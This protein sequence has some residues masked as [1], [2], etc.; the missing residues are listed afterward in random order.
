MIPATSGWGDHTHMLA[1]GFEIEPGAVPLCVEHRA[2]SSH[3]DNLHT[4]PESL[5]EIGCGLRPPE[6]RGLPCPSLHAVHVALLLG[7]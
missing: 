6:T 5:Q 1:K 7:H 4:I 2:G 3:K